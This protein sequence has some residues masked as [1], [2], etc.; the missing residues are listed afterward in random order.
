MGR[1]DASSER[2]EKRVDNGVGIAEK[3]FKCVGY[4]IIKFDG[5]LSAERLGVGG[6]P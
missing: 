5:G 3:H 2:C 1:L 6:L 4:I